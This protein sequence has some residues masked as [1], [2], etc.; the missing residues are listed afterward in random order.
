[1]RHD[2]RHIT[3]IQLVHCISETGYVGFAYELISSYTVLGV[4]GN[5]E[6]ASE[7]GSFS[8]E[9]VVRGQDAKGLQV[10]DD[11]ELIHISRDLSKKG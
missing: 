2:L 9:G 11:R 7:A 10:R 5:S 8:F 4:D 1:M 6:K 3:P